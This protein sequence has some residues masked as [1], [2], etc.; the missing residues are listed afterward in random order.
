MSSI[1]KLAVPATYTD[2]RFTHAIVMD[3]LLNADDRKMP[4]VVAIFVG[5]GGAGLESMV[6]GALRWPGATKYMRLWLHKAGACPGMMESGLV[7]GTLY[8]LY[9]FD[10][11]LQHAE[12]TIVR[13]RRAAEKRRASSEKKAVNGVKEAT[14]KYVP[15]KSYVTSEANKMAAKDI[16]AVTRFA[17]DRYERI[18]AQETTRADL[19]AADEESAAAELED[20]KRKAQAQAEAQAQ[21]QWALAQAQAQAAFDAARAYALAT[22]KYAPARREGNGMVYYDLM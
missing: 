4:S 22:Y 12:D 20:A 8:L 18:L 14:E 11:Y 15:A 3:R 13:E 17:T 7:C 6:K 9:D 2:S 10:A 1:Q 19:K 16:D 5:T 21:A